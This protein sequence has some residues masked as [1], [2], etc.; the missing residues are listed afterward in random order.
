MAAQRLSKLQR[1]IM[2]HL[3][4]QYQ[5]T[6][7]GIAMGHLELAQTLGHDKGNLSHSLKTLEARGWVEVG[8][9]PGG[10]A[11]YVD[12]TPEGRKLAC[13]IEQGCD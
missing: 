2:R 13:K 3:F 11:D 10:Q 8:R 6:Q 7:G 4:A 1:R 12:L 5:R 9:T